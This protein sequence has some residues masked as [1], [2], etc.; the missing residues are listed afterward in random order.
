MP[1]H[2]E[3]IVWLTAGQSRRA[4]R[5]SSG[6]GVGGGAWPLVA[7]AGATSSGEGD[8]RAK[9]WGTEVAL[10]VQ[11]LPGD[12]RFVAWVVGRD[13]RREQA[14]TWAGTPTGEARLAGASSIPRD[15]VMLLTV[16][17]GDGTPLLELR[18]S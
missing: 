14:A 8:L 2:T 15:Q 9:P 3:Q 13:G 11:G 6:V 10:R 17:T 4:L 1:Q 18:P 16:T 5:S 7:V 12:D